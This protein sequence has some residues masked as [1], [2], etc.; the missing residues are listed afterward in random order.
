MKKN[1]FFIIALSLYLICVN[2]S[3]AQISR[4]S[5]IDTVINHILASDT[6]RADIYAAYDLLN[7]GD[8]VFQRDGLFITN[9]YPYSW[10]FFIDDHPMANWFHDCRYLFMNEA[11]GYY[12]S[13]NKRIFPEPWEEDFELVSGINLPEPPEV[14]NPPGN[15]KDPLAPNPYLHAVIICGDEMF[16]RYWR[17]TSYI[18]TTLKEKGFIDENIV[19]HYN[20]GSSNFPPPT[21]GADFDK[22]QLD[23]IDYPAFKDPIKSTFKAYA[24]MPGGNPAIP[25]LQPY[26]HLFIFTTNHGDL[27]NG[28]ASIRILHK[29]SPPGLDYLYDYELADLLEGINCAHMAIVMS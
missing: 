14:I 24:G 18:F 4:Q 12:Q 23:D 25:Q 1:L 20:N 26:D 2:I 22:D 27:N 16:S 21:Y 13:F 8:T 11:D 9:P 28:N 10:V 29:L 19:V 17:N 3:K 6:G 5:A 15:P 7:Q